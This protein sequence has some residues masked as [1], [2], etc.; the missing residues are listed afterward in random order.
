MKNVFI[1]SVAVLL[2]TTSCAHK[3]TGKNYI[4]IEPWKEWQIE[5]KLNQDSTFGLTDRFGCNVFDY[6]G[7]WHYHRDSVFSFLILND[8][9]KAVYI[10]S[11]NAYQFFNRKT[12]KQQIVRADQYFPVISIDTILILNNKRLRFRGLTFV[13]QKLFSSKNL[14]KKREQMIEVFYFDKI[15]KEH[16]I[17]TFGD[18]K[19]L[20]EARKNIIECKIN[21]IPIASFDK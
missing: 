21:P 7:Q 11:H 4:A 5:L 6:S 8:T 9:A 19:G 3:L 18:G 2:L 16:F 10:K 14:S 12:Q 20:K 17:K 13:R 1:I 15:G